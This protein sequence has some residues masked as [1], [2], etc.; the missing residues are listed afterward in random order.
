MIVLA[1]IAAN[2]SVPTIKEF[3][4]NLYNKTYGHKLLCVATHIHSSSQMGK[5]NMFD[6]LTGVMIR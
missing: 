3:V 4:I 1:D 6:K 5:V 2:C